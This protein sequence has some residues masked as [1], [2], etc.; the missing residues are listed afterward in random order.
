M[1]PHS[2]SEAEMT[3]PPAAAQATRVGDV[4]TRRVSTIGPHQ[5]L[6][7]AHGL[8]MWGNVRHLPVVQDGKL[9]GVLSDR[10]LLHKMA[11]IAARP[12]P[13]AI[14]ADVMTQPVETAHPDEDLGEAA[15]RM[16][17]KRIDCLPVVRD[18]ELVGIVSTTDVLAERGRLFF[19]GGR[20]DVPS[21]GHIMRPATE[22]A[23]AEDDLFDAIGAMVEGDFRHLPIVDA[24]GTI[25][26]MLSDRDVRS[27]VGDPLDV[28][29]EGEG[30]VAGRRVSDAMKTSPATI[31]KDA[32][33]ADL[34]SFLLD[35]RV[36]ALPVVDDG[37]RL[38]GIVSY[39]D[40]LSHVI[41]TR[42]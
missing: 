42:G 27:A 18:G 14:T 39:V 3:I 41:A 15:A 36:G 35:E 30:E 1:T 11:E 25:V 5:D 7:F 22:T 13:T 31:S 6:A 34:A 26:G 9:V 21:V 37:D 33:L 10:D 12:D 20:V 29:R 2:Q 24:E 40:L 38:V 17:A 23:N 19:K 4:M 16:A 28:L 8:M 32:S